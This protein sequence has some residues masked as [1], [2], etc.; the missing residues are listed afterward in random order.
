[1]PLH[2]KKSLP[3][4][5]LVDGEQVR[6]H[7]KRMSVGEF[8]TFEAEFWARG[9]GRRMAI[10][11]DTSPGESP[12]VAFD[13]KLQQKTESALDYTTWLRDVFERFVT[14]EPGDLTLEDEPIT[15]GGR[16]VEVLAFYGNVVP[17]VLQQLYLRNRISEE[18]KKTSVLRLASRTGSR[19]DPPQAASGDAPETT[20]PGADPSVSAES[21]VVTASSES[22]SSGTTVPSS[23]EAAPSAS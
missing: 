4:V 16:F 2:L 17:E 7:L 21:E 1:M 8:A 14:V 19:I 12:E 3:Y 9:K 18:Q 5:V 6:L 11:E 13:R 23:S 10:E 15:S 20:A 22:A